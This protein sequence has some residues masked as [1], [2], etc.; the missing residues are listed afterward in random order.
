MAL[1]TRIKYCYLNSYS[2]I[3]HHYSSSI[4]KTTTTITQIQHKYSFST[5]NKSLHPSRQQSSQRNNKTQHNNAKH[6][7]NPEYA[8]QQSIQP[9]IIKNNKSKG[10]HYIHNLKSRIQFTLKQ[11]QELQ[12]KQQNGYTLNQSQLAKIQ[13]KAEL[14]EKLDQI[15]AGTFKLYEHHTNPSKTHHSPPTTKLQRQTPSTPPK[16]PQSH[17]KSHSLSITP[18]KRHEIK[19]IINYKG[20]DDMDIK[21]KFEKLLSRPTY[22]IWA[23]RELFAS[24]NHDEWPQIPTQY[25]RHILDA[26][27]VRNDIIFVYKI[28]MKWFQKKMGNRY[29]LYADLCKACI[30]GNNLQMAQEVFQYLLYQLMTRTK[31]D[32]DDSIPVLLY[33]IYD[34]MN[35]LI[36]KIIECGQFHI[37]DQLVS[38]LIELKD[39]GFIHDMNGILSNSNLLLLWK[40]CVQNE[41]ITRLFVI[42]QWINQEK[43]VDLNANKDE[44]DGDEND[45][46]RFINRL[47]HADI[48]K[49]IVLAINSNNKQLFIEIMALCG[50]RIDGDFQDTIVYCI[51]HG[52]LH[53][54][55]SDDTNWN[56]SMV[57]DT[58]R[59]VLNDYKLFEKIVDS[60]CVKDMN[61]HKNMAFT[62]KLGLKS[63]NIVCDWLLRSISKLDVNNDP[64][65]EIMND[66]IQ[67]FVCIECYDSI[68]RDNIGDA[69]KWIELAEKL[70]RNMPDSVLS[71]IDASAEFNGIICGLQLMTFMRR[72]EMLSQCINNLPD[73]VIGKY[74]WSIIDCMICENVNLLQLNHDGIFIRSDNRDS[75]QM[76][77]NVKMINS[78]FEIIQILDELHAVGNIVNNGWIKGESDFRMDLEEKLQSLDYSEIK[79]KTVKYPLKET[80]NGVSQSNQRYALNYKG[81]NNDDDLKWF[82]ALSDFAFNEK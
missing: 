25:I 43:N 62:N 65:A 57:I 7:N 19:H 24:F 74:C 31:R 54:V 46:K 23:V 6:D 33:H 66:M 3:I 2:L 82:D 35:L 48:M 76:D 58:N 41:S 61:E 28:L 75:L 15:R 18:M 68:V 37:F 47:D 8:K 16:S 70:L 55:L 36:P 81:N 9:M 78:A 53:S 32:M 69:T 50:N 63:W 80:H 21:E 17:Q 71:R 45:L 4:T 14:K 49:A 51:E 26:Y 67:Y 40:S 20:N 44:D 52:L 39:N 73:V 34:T 59:I 30:E 56:L 64:I 29:E 79:P 5:Q 10:A 77:E 11:I 1:T 72:W 27:Y 42:I 38:Q 12:F 22:S 60:Y 13:R